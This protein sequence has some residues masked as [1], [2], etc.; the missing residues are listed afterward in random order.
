M[1]P[2]S[3]SS[4][5]LGVLS[6]LRRLPPRNCPGLHSPHI[7]FTATSCQ[8][9]LCAGKIGVARQ[10]PGTTGALL[11]V[12][13]GLNS[14]HWLLSPIGCLCHSPVRFPSSNPG[15]CYYPTPHPQDKHTDNTH[16]RDFSDDWEENKQNTRKKEKQQEKRKEGNST[17]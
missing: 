10:G 13:R 4:S 12:Q 7:F 2:A 6:E 15:S 8:A 11:L 3:I 5:S 9:L 16:S 14:H 17:D 1:L